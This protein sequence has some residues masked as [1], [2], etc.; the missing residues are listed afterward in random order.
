MEFKMSVFQCH[1]LFSVSIHISVTML[2]GNVI[3]VINAKLLVWPF[4][5]MTHILSTLLK[6]C[7]ITLLAYI[8][9]LQFN[10]VDSL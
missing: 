1:L 7:R 5:N 10:V 2:F 9:F 6:V 4:I 3:N 8:C